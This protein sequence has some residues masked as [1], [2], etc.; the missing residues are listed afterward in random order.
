MK[1]VLRNKD[2]GNFLERYLKS[3]CHAVDGIV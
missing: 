1:P 3:F 2:K